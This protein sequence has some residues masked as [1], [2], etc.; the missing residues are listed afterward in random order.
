MPPP[1]DHNSD[2]TLV[3]KKRLV[4]VLTRLGVINSSEE[5]VSA[6]I[7]E[8]WREANEYCSP[9]GYYK[10]NYGGTDVESDHWHDEIEIGMLKWILY[11][12]SANQPSWFS[13][14]FCMPCYK[15]PD[16]RIVF[17]EHPGSR[18]NQK[19]GDLVSHD[20]LSCYLCRNVTGSTQAV[21][22]QP[23]RSYDNVQ[24]PPYSRKETESDE[25]LDDEGTLEIEIAQTIL[26]EHS[27]NTVMSP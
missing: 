12:V 10:E 25:S 15:V 9:K 14:I 22:I 19:S 1:L 2:K 17:P 7:D 21:D 4:C 3:S 24:P 27:T 18:M 16:N 11:G 13:K 20:V 23:A 6:M 5:D 26:K 8:L